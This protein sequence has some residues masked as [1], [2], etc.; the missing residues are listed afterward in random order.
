MGSA[1]LC[2]SGARVLSCCAM[3]CAVCCVP[4]CAVLCYAAGQSCATPHRTAPHRETFTINPPCRMRVLYT[5]PQL[6]YSALSYTG[7]IPDPHGCQGRITPRHPP[8]H[9]TYSTVAYFPPPPLTLPP[10]PTPPTCSTCVYCT[11][12]NQC[13]TVY[14][15]IYTV[16]TALCCFE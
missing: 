12:F 9:L 8:T 6:P 1:P 13:T 3:L 2:S 4:C 11:I 5:V 10:L 14:M 16:Y 15:Y 7:A